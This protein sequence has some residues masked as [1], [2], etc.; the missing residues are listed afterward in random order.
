MS[1]VR[2]VWASFDLK[3]PHTPGS[4]AGKHRPTPFPGQPRASYLSV[5]APPLALVIHGWVCLTR[6]FA[7]HSPKA[8]RLDARHPRI[9]RYDALATACVR[10]R[11]LAPVA[12]YVAPALREHMTMAGLNAVSGGVVDARAVTEVADLQGVGVKLAAGRLNLECGARVADC[13]ELCNPVLSTVDCQSRAIA[14]EATLAGLEQVWKVCAEV[15]V[16][17]F[18]L[19]QARVGCDSADLLPGRHCAR[20]QDAGRRTHTDLSP[21]DSNR[22]FETGP[23]SQ[24]KPSVSRITASKHNKQALFLVHDDDETRQQ[25]LFH[26]QAQ[27]RAGPAP[28]GLPPPC[29][30]TSTC[31]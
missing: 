18:K 17:C 16:N 24:F 22:S 6:T 1:C 4:N 15:L 26:A 7:R 3:I 12:P 14:K 9:P 30:A 5:L 25:E 13:H 8:T 28:A 29:S 19:S 10:A 27:Q 31:Q 11:A 2:C 23:G 20:Q 21:A